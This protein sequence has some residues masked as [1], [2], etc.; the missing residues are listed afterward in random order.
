MTN[1]SNTGNSQLAIRKSH[2]FALSLVL[3]STLLFASAAQACIL[4]PT[5]NGGWAATCVQTNDSG[6]VYLAVNGSWQPQAYYHVIDAQWMHIYY[7]GPRVW[8]NQNRYNGLIWVWTAAGWT[9]YR[10][11]EAQALTLIKAL[12]GLSQ[13]QTSTT[14]TIQ[15]VPAS[16]VN[17]T[18]SAI[19]TMQLRYAQWG[20][21]PMRYSFCGQ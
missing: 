20:L 19:R 1:E 14:P 3:F 15:I 18:C 6:Y 5:D 12:A 16:F 10:T 2:A 4:T 9:P 13:S 7:Y 21:P 17:D 11:Y 8:T